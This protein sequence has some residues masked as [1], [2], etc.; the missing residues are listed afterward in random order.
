M[1]ITRVLSALSSLLEHR[2]RVRFDALP[3]IWAVN[4]LFYHLVYWWTAVG[5]AR[6][7]SAWT[8]PVFLA[9]FLY[10]V[11]LY[12]CATLVLPAPTTEAIDL[13]ERFEAVRKPFFSVWITVALL[14]ILDTFLKGGSDRIL[15]ELG[16]PYVATLGVALAFGAGALFITNRAYNWVLAVLTFV[17]VAGWI[18][19]RWAE[20]S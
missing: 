17:G 7:Q 4:V 3:I 8:F 16:L 5:N 18:L 1:G 20:I 6:S 9:L 15:I 19:G 10:G 14:E 13:R 2:E 12:F 11:A